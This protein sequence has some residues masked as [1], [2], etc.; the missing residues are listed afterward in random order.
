MSE[1][2]TQAAGLTASAAAARVEELQRAESELRELLR[3]ER[4]EGPHTAAEVAG[5]MAKAQAEV[6]AF[7]GRIDA[8]K[9]EARALKAE[10]V[11]LERKYEEVPEAERGAEWPTLVGEKMRRLIEVRVREAHIAAL[12]AQK[13][14]ALGTLEAAKQRLAAVEAGAD[15]LPLEKDPRLLSLQEEMAA[16]AA[17]KP[18]KPAGRRPK[19]KS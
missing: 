14:A 12:E 18:R 4:E 2:E 19:K 3:R 8:V 9:G 16:A 10:V 17:P 15:R 7:Q 13:W 6:E 11:E 5:A 1:T